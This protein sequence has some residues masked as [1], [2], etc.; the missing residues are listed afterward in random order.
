MTIREYY[1]AI[2]ALENLPTELREYTEKAIEKL[3]AKND[4]AHTRNSEKKAEELRPLMEAISSYL[5]GKDY[6]LTSE[7]AVAVS[8]STSKASSV[9]RKMTENGMLLS[10]DKKL[11]KV[12]VRKAY[13]LA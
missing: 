11:P 12:G 1:V 13:K 4:A 9:L 2:S 7:I 8:V 6:T 10:V 5:Q 3:D